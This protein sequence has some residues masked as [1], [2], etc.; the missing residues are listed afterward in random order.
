VIHVTFSFARVFTSVHTHER[1]LTCGGKPDWQHA[2]SKRN[3][4]NTI[5]IDTVTAVYVKQCWQ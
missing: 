5:P 4:Q 1:W 2:S 3:K